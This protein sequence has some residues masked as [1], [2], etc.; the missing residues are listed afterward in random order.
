MGLIDEVIVVGDLYQRVDP[1]RGTPERDGHARYRLSGMICYYG[2]H[3]VG[4]LTREWRRKRT[5]GGAF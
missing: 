4:A 3:Y 1:A 2:L 5:V